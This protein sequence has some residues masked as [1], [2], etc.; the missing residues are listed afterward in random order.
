MY[1][2]PLSDSPDFSYLFSNTAPYLGWRFNPDRPTSVLSFIGQAN[3]VDL[4][5]T[6]RI[7]NYVSEF[8]TTYDEY[9][10]LRVV[11]ELL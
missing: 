11:F 3:P 9:Y 8:S 4:D 5:I 2:I 10:Q 6:T 7:R 1:N